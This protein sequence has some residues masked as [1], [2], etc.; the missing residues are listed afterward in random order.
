[1]EASS[2]VPSIIVA[3]NQYN[4]CQMLYILIQKKIFFTHYRHFPCP[5]NFR[6]VCL[7]HFR[8]LGWALEGPLGRAL[9]GALRETLGALAL[10]LGGHLPL[11][12]S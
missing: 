11:S 2:V 4:T 10:A 8:A 7:H 6:A 9:D 12:S 5:V 3:T 1:M